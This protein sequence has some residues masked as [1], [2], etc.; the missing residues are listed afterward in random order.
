MECSA[1][2][3]CTNPGRQAGETREKIRNKQ[4]RQ[5]KAGKPGWSAL[6]VLWARIHRASWAKQG[7]EEVLRW[8][9]AM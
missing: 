6:V 7:Q 2:G 4:M 9:K 1:A 5:G 8:D 3:S